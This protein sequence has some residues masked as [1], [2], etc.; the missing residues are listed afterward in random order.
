MVKQGGSK[1][2]KV[3][4]EVAN[5]LNKGKFNKNLMSMSGYFNTLVDPFNVHGEKIPDM[6]NYP[7]STF[8]IVF[9]NA[10]LLN[11]SGNGSFCYG[12]AGNAT[13][14]SCSLVP[15]KWTQAVF[16]T[17]NFSF[18]MFN[19][20]AAGPTISDLFPAA[21]TQIQTLPQWTA[22]VGVPTLYSKVRLVSAGFAID[23][24]GTALNAKGTITIVSLPRNHFRSDASAGALSL[25]QIQNSPGARIIPINRLTGGTCVYHPLDS[26][27]MNYVDLRLTYD[28][29]SLT[30]FSSADSALGGEIFI[31]VRDAE[32]SASVQI[33]C[34]L[35]YEGI[36]FLSTLNLIGSTSSR[37][38]PIELSMTMNAVENVPKAH[39]GTEAVQGVATGET[40]LPAAAAPNH[41]SMTATKPVVSDPEGPTF[42]EKMLGGADS[43]SSAVSTGLGLVKKVAPLAEMALGFL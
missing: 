9:K 35:N 38:D 41:S 28:N 21:T 15:V 13:N 36:P 10:S 30:T 33:T 37:S 27:S 8:S 16:G 18:G 40:Q 32:A 17:T 6:V 23:Y 29:A 26:V 22:T 20:N 11:A 42:M 31:I 3:K 19:I 4:K 43:L 25:S 7:S 14:T 2:K 39:E 5:L 12:M 1:K 24:L 34:V